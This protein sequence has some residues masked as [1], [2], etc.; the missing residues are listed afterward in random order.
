MRYELNSKSTLKKEL[1]M[2]TSYMIG[3]RYDVFVIA[4]KCT[5]VFLYYTI[6]MFLSFYFSITMKLHPWLVYVC[7]LDTVNR[8]RVSAK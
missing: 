2:P 6:I 8:K 3:G 4:N 7:C 5:V 1:F